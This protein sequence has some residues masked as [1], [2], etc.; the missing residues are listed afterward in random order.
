M[1]KHYLYILY[2]SVL[3]GL[4]SLAACSFPT[5]GGTDDVTYTYPGVA[6]THMRTYQNEEQA[7]QHRP[8]PGRWVETHVEPGFV[9]VFECWEN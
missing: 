5:D 3:L 6:C 2:I 1:K 9:E 4:L 7:S 8:A